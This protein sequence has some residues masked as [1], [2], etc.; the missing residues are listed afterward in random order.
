MVKS[1]DC[2]R[3][4]GLHIDADLKFTKHINQTITKAKVA[5]SMIHKVLRNK[6]IKTNIKILVYRLCIKPILTYAWPVWCNTSKSDIH[7]L[8]I[9]QNKCLNI[10][11]CN[12][13]SNTNYIRMDDCH[14][15]TKLEYIDKFIERIAKN[16]YTHLANNV[17]NIKEMSKYSISTWLGAEENGH[18]KKIVCAGFM[19]PR[20][21]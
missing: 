17:T 14:Q 19:K 3:Y 12:Y 2:V 5:M 21:K 11:L 16:S 18:T 4:L 1:V 6:H 13:I 10:I 7:K 8:Q 9:I 20:C 15:M